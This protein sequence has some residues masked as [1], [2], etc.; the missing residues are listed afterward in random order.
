MAADEF[1]VNFFDIFLLLQT[2]NTGRAQSSSYFPG[3]F[4]QPVFNQLVAN[5]E[6]WQVGCKCFY[7]PMENASTSNSLIRIDDKPVYF[8][9]WIKKGIS[10]VKN[11]IKQDNGEKFLSHI[12]FK[13]TYETDTSFLSYFG[14][15]SCLIKLQKQ[16][17]PCLN[18]TTSQKSNLIKNLLSGQ[19]ATKRLL[20][21]AFLKEKYTQPLDAQKKWENDCY[22]TNLDEA[23]WK[24]INFI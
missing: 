15:I 20:Y 16:I 13:T 9:K 4:V 21:K 2:E 10:K 23:T 6:P 14:L 8:Q 5:F 19:S 12:E 7:V 3:A 17:K 1:L 18:S 11:L 22:L 24:N